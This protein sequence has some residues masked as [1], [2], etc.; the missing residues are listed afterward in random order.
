MTVVVVD[1]EEEDEDELEEDEDE[2]LDDDEDELEEDEDEEEVPVVPQIVT[3]ESVVPVPMPP[4]QIVTG[5]PK[6][7][8]ESTN[9]K[10]IATSPGESVAPGAT[11]SA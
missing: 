11:V 5:S 6:L 8:V 10:L 3:A 9:A 2:E 7:L 4:V 1:E